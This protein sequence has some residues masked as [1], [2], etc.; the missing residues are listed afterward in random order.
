M[1]HYSYHKGF[2]HFTSPRSASDVL[3]SDGTCGK[4]VLRFTPTESILRDLHLCQLVTSLDTVA[5]AVLR[6]YYN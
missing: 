4:E 3:G 2:T 6:V 1:L 5:L